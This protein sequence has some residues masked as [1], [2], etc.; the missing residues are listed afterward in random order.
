MTTQTPKRTLHDRRQAFDVAKEIVSQLQAYASRVEICG[1]L[2][3]DRPSVHDIEILY[4]P[5]VAVKPADLFGDESQMVDLT[6]KFFNVLLFEGFLAKRP[7]VKGHTAWGPKNKL[8]I[9]VA[10]GI[11][12]D[13]FATTDLNWWN[14]LF[15]RTGG[16]RMNLMVTMAANKKGYSFEAYGCGFRCLTED[17]IKLNRCEEDIFEFVGLKYLEPCLRP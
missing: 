3:R 6:E 2:R 5:K 9:H 8:A 1:S 10:S 13:F 12:V 4:I 17:L 11:P 7:N 15:V 14:S 16:K